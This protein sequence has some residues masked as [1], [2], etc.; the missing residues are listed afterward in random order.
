MKTPQSILSATGMLA[1]ILAVGPPVVLAQ[2]ADNS[3]GTVLDSA[4]AR[5]TVP[6]SNPAATVLITVLTPIGDG[7]QTRGNLQ[8][9]QAGTAVSVTGR[10]EGLETNKRYQVTFRSAGNRM[11]E[12]TDAAGSAADPPSEAGTPAAGPPEAG[13]P[14]AGAPA[15]GKPNG[16]IRPGAPGAGTEGTPVAGTR[17]P[18]PEAPAIPLG[19]EKELGTMLSDSTGASN[20]NTTLRNADLTEGPNGILGGTIII[21]AAPPL[22]T[23]TER[24]AVA[25]GVIRAAN[26]GNANPAEPNGSDE[27][28]ASGTPPAR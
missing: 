11:M 2:T 26:T 5:S 15:A 16:E 10:V 17:N 25:S 7:V 14:A 21:K 9:S 8:F 28:P 13:P 22:D 20:V 27:T 1:A 19:P 12:K 23:P 3:T 4:T 6:P 24:P 18:N